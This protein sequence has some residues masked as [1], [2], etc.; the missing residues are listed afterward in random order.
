[1]T[2]GFARIVNMS[3]ETSASSYFNS[4]AIVEEE[5]YTNDFVLIPDLLHEIAGAVHVIEGYADL[6]AEAQPAAHV[7]RYVGAISLSAKRLGSLAEAMAWCQSSVGSSTEPVRLQELL[8]EAIS[9]RAESLEQRAIKVTHQIDSRVLVRANAACVTKLFDLIIDQVTSQSPGGETIVVTSITEPSTAR[10]RLVLPSTHANRLTLA[11]L[12]SLAQA[13]G[14]EVDVEVT[15]SS[16][17]LVIRFVNLDDTA[18]Q[19]ERHVLVLHVED[20]SATRELVSAILTSPSLSVIPAASVVEA[21]EKLEEIRP[22]LLVVDHQ[23]GE[24]RG[25]DLVRYIRGHHD[26]KSLPIVMLSAEM[27]LDLT[28]EANA[29]GARLV[30]KPVS[31]S[32]LLA[33][34]SEMFEMVEP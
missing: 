34:V 21:R 24:E 2:F 23:L 32:H 27:A 4:F 10:L 16:S 22:N 11:L 29:L 9:R 33:V 17:I 28:S 26:L 20:D 6:I 18:A 19:A 31:N 30:Q 7:Q 5:V 25:L 13:S 15:G 14:V 12:Q 8:V 1:M 3:S